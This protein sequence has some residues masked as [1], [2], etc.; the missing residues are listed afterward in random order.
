[1][2]RVRACAICVG[3]QVQYLQLQS[4]VAIELQCNNEQMIA[5]YLEV[6]KGAGNVRVRRYRWLECPGRGRHVRTF[7]RG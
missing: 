7:L 5:D 1:M 2:A 4:K 6:G 3:R